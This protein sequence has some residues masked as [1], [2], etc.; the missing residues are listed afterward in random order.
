MAQIL[1]DYGDALAMTGRGAESAKPLEEAEAIAKELKNDNVMADIQN[2]Q[3][4]VLFFR[5][6]PKGAKDLYQRAL[7]TATRAK[8]QNRIL[9]SKF[10]IARADIALHQPQAAVAA[11]KQIVTQA[12]SA[13]LKYLHFRL[14]FRSRRRPQLRSPIPKL[15]RSLNSC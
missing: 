12:D 15:G 6:D 7:Q 4:N 3:G 5:G 13:G 9:V 8:D 11:L 14:Q 1:N 10:D 2:T